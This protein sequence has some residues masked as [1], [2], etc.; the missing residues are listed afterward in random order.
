MVWNRPGIDWGTRSILPLPDF[1]T[2]AHSLPALLGMG[3]RSQFAAA[4]Q[5]TMTAP[6]QILVLSL[7]LPLLLLEVSTARR[8]TPLSIRG[9]LLAD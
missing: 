9:E 5:L 4:N 1:V 7:Q 6:S 8:M 2:G 3:P